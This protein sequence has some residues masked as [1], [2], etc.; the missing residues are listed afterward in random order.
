MKKNKRKGESNM[1]VRG[2]FSKYNSKRVVKFYL[3]RNDLR[4]RAKKLLK[5]RGFNLNTLRSDVS[6]SLNTIADI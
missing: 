6:Y 4:K 1:A 5:K 3:F 2:R